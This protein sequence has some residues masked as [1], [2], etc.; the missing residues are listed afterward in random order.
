MDILN[1][2]IDFAKSNPELIVGAGVILAILLLIWIWP[3]GGQPT[4][5]LKRKIDLLQN[6]FIRLRQDARLEEGGDLHDLMAVPMRQWPHDPFAFY[7]G[8]LAAVER[9]AQS[10]DPIT[11]WPEA[12]ADQNVQITANDFMLLMQAVA[13]QNDPASIVPRGQI[14]EARKAHAKHLIRMSHLGKG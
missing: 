1:E 10:A 2:V 7:K 11:A 12:K 13:A 4:G 3:K 14:P 8:A 6:N 9:M 5:G